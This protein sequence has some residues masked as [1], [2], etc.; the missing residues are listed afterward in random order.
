M[1][2][3]MENWRKFI[4]EM[5]D[6]GE[7]TEATPEEQE[8]KTEEVLNNI[9][10]NEDEVLKFFEDNPE[11]ADEII[12]A[13]EE[14]ISEG[15]D[16]RDYIDQSPEARKSREE[17]EEKVAKEGEPSITEDLSALTTFVGSASALMGTLGIVSDSSYFDDTT[18]A[19]M[20]VG[21]LGVAGV[22]K[23][24]NALAKAVRKSKASKNVEKL[25]ERKLTSAEKKKKEKIVKGMKSSKKDFEKR[26]PGRGEEVMYATA[27]KEAKKK[28]KKK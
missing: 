20:I 12:K 1:K 8:S 2:L 10:T 5:E 4:N 13:A 21:G 9:E 25:Q 18:L 27:A 15:Y 16:P 3:L 23:I 28:K 24:V 6:V 14:E 11:I 17:Y 26:Y 22:S 19:Q 7:T